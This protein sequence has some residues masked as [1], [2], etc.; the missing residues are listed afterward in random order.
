[1]VVGVRSTLEGE[2]LTELDEL[3]ARDGTERLTELLG[4]ETEVL[5]RETELL[6]RLT[7]LDERLL[8]PTERELPPEER[9]LDWPPELPDEP[10]R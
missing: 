6:G 5:G 2:R 9:A 7:E 3:V 10:R 1:M 8:E 4:R